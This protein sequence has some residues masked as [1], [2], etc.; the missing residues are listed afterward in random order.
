MTS[1]GELKEEYG[2]NSSFKQAYSPEYLGID[3]PWPQDISLVYHKR[4][5]N[6]DNLCVKF[7]SK[8]LAVTLLMD[9]ERVL[10][11]IYGLLLGCSESG[12]GL[13]DQ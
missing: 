9:L 8:A 5:P 3:W 7:C 13:L 2:H 6:S 4:E 12:L 1:T 10:L 11:G